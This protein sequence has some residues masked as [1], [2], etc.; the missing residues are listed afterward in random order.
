[1]KNKQ[2]RSKLER[3]AVK[4]FLQSFESKKN[5][6]ILKDIDN[7]ELLKTKRKLRRLVVE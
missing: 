3:E 2:D 5:N 4:H 7:K 6:N 1:M